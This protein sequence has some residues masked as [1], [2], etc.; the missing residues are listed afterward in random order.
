[1][2]NIL[3]TPIDETIEWASRKGFRAWGLVHPKGDWYVFCQRPDGAIFY[4]IPSMAIQ[5]DDRDAV[6]DWSIDQLPEIE[7]YRSEWRRLV[8]MG[9]RPV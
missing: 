6:A 3:E 8:E 1:M 9:Y 7:H 5:L 2:N 4:V